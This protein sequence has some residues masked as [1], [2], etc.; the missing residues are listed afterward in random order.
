MGRTVVKL[1][2]IPSI[3]YVKSMGSASYLAH[4]VLAVSVW[5]FGASLVKKKTEERAYGTYL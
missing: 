4:E 1:L 5:V 3:K 2:G